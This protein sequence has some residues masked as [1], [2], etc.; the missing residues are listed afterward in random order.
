MAIKLCI[1]GDSNVDR[2]FAKVKSARNDPCFQNA[3]VV[4]ATNLAQVKAALC[5]P[6][7][8]EARSHVLLACAT[9]PIADYQFTDVTALLKHCEAIF[10]QLK[11][12]IAEGRANVPGDLEQV[13]FCLFIA[14]IILFLYCDFYLSKRIILFVEGLPGATYVPR[15][16]L[17]V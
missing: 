15:V 3:F 4:R 10:T 17:L 5:P 13:I 1:I 2:H 9:N 11:S 6:E 14:S 8:A 12:F 16:S 7:L